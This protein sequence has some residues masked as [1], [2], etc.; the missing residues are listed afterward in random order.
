MGTLD[1]VSWFNHRRLV[2]SIS[3]ISLAEAGVNY[4]QRLATGDWRLAEQ[5]TIEV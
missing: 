2:E 4:Y 5:A 1:W 3:Y